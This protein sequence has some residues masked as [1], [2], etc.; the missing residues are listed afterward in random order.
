MNEEDI[1]DI[2]LIL[3]GETGV[4]KTSIIK[5]YI[6]DEFDPTTTTSL[7]TSYVGKLIEKDNKKIKLNIWD[8]VGQEK[9]RSISQ[10]FLKNTKIVIMVYSIISQESFDN[11]DYWLNLYKT[12]I[13]DGT[14]FNY[15]DNFRQSESSNSFLSC[16]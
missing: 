16:I 11:L 7:T 15:N 10:L 2:K 5:R 3:L 4:G 13:D 1:L 14:N 6:N 12:Q 9:F 8:T